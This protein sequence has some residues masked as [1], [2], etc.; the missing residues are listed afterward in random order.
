GDYVGNRVDSTATV[1]LGLALGG[2]RCHDHKFDPFTQ[3]EYYQL[4]A[5]FNNVAESGGVDSEGQA[6]PVLSLATPEQTRQLAEQT[7]HFNDLDRRWKAAAK[8]R[9]PL[10]Q[11]RCDEGGEQ[12][13]EIRPAIDP[14]VKSLNRYIS[15]S[16]PAER[17]NYRKQ[18][19]E[20]E[21][22][23]GEL[24]KALR[25]TRTELDELQKLEDERNAAS[26][27]LDKTRGA[28][29]RVMAMQ[30]RPQPRE[31]HVLIRGA[32]DKPGDR[33]SPGVPAVLPALTTDPPGSPNRLNLAR[34]LVSPEH[35]LTARVA[36][37][38]AWQQFFGTGLVKTAEDFG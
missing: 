5:F 6:A 37:N 24:T 8:D 22:R 12:L 34:W 26:N 14:L 13:G 17:E 9:L 30:E 21:R 32:W 29:P 1:W 20:L 33:V 38:R 3:K 25:D 35:P 10:A 31:T 18:L 11:K 2:P 36:V 7:R 16:Y 23:S 28:I 19:A 15:A 27:Q 4:F